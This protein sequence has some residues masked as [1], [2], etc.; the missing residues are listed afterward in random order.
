MSTHPAIVEAREVIALEQA[1]ED[2]RLRRLWKAIMLAPD[3]RTCEA[4]L[5][6]E[7]VPTNRLD[8]AWVHRFGRR[9]SA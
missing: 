1:L 8:P 7:P 9:E 3:I 6:H 2:A 4:L 5:R